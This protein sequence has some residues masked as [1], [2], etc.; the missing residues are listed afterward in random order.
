MLDEK[1]REVVRKLLDGTYKF[2]REF[3][4]PL[5]GKLAFT[6]S[7]PTEPQFTA[8]TVE[9]DNLLA[10]LADGATPRVTTIA[11][12]TAVAGVRTMLTLP[13]VDQEV[14][15]DPESEGVEK[16][17]RTV[18]YEPGEDPFPNFVSEV[19]Q[20]FS[21]WRDESLS[22]ENIEALKNTSGETPGS[23][24]DA[25]SSARG[26]SPSTTRA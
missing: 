24:S 19:W 6:G 8:Q 14:I 9:M 3:D 17:V 10:S 15:D 13:M 11:W 26:G 23:D 12:V 7:L 22:S 1:T 5:Y 4:H 20:A 21:K 25:S 16:K 2:E 18:Y